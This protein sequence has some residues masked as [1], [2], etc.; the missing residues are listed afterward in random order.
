MWMLLASVSG[1]L[2]FNNGETISYGG[3][4]G[5]LRK[6][7]VMSCNL[8]VERM[9]FRHPMAFITIAMF[10]LGTFCAARTVYK[11]LLKIADEDGDGFLSVHEVV[12][13]LN[14]APRQVLI[15]FGL[16]QENTLASLQE[17]SD[18]SAQQP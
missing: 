16:L 2:V 8:L 14:S 9:S 10:S 3:Y 12:H 4:V 7:I 11:T 15:A 17:T 18:S 5:L 1:L 6:A 13:F